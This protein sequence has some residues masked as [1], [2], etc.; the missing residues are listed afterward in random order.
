MTLLT[1]VAALALAG[2]AAE[3][4][5]ADEPRL[6]LR[7]QGGIFLPTGLEGSDCD[8]YT[9]GDP[10]MDRGVAADLA[11]GYQLLPRVALEV[12]TGFS[13]VVNVEPAVE[14]VPG[15]YMQFALTR[16]PLT[17]G[18]RAGLPGSGLRA[19]AG[20]G[21]YFSTVREHN[22]YT[23]WAYSY[24][25]DE[26][27]QAVAFGGYAGVA[28][29]VSIGPATRLGVELRYVKTATS[30]E[31][32]S[33]A[34]DGFQLTGG[35]T[36]RFGEGATVSRSAPVSASP[37]PDA[38]PSAGEP[39]ADS[40]A[41][42]RWRFLARLGGFFPTGTDL[43]HLGTGPE[44]ELGVAQYFTP[45]VAAELAVGGF[46]AKNAQATEQLPQLIVVPVTIS[47]RG[48]LPLGASFEASAYA[49]AGAYVVNYNQG[50]SRNETSVPPGLHVGV[51]LAARTWGEGSIGVDARL[52]VAR[53]SL[54]QKPGPLASGEPL[55][56]S[57]LRIGVA[58]AVPL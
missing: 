30:F 58:L 23:D 28:W 54:G 44:A 3:V 12:G 22:G 13:R 18:L 2:S 6:S 43:A 36:Y 37:A 8:P 10:F 42:N 14:T 25:L 19:V 39:V 40:A 29:D 1:L 33:Y 56:V 34:G 38:A 31:N 49:G 46:G 15:D 26:E 5:R 50:G 47:A 4:D 35:L 51:G 48:I 17:V 32:L 57:G 20:A 11:V 24:Q 9:C 21:A 52:S 16:V 53:T 27:E 45:H 55:T 7:V 41:G